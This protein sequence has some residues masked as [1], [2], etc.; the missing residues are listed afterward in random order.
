MWTVRAREKRNRKWLQNLQLL[1]ETPHRW[2]ACTCR[3]RPLRWASDGSLL[4]E[5]K[6]MLQGIHVDSR[7][8]KITGIMSLSFRKE[9]YCK[10]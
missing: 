7:G 10:C 9:K 5:K 2:A 3:K 4:G 1:G 8:F 6:K